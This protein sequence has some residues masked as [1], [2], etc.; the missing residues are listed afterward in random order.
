MGMVG[1]PAA[2]SQTLPNGFTVQTLATGISRPTCMAFAP[3]GRLFI[4]EQNGAIKVYKNG[5][6]LGTSF[7]Q[8]SVNNSGERGLLGLEFDP[9]YATNGYVYV[10]YTQPVSPIRNQVSRLTSNPA[11]PDVMLA[12]SESLVLEFDPLNATNHNG[13]SIKFGPDG[14]LYVAIGENAVTANAQNYDNYLGKLLRINADGSAPADNPF[15]TATPDGTPPT[16]ASQRLW[17]LGLRNPYSFAIDPSAGTIFVNDV[18][19]NQYE[20]INDATLGGNNF[21]WPTQEGPPLSPFAGPAYY[22]KNRYNGG[23]TDSSGCSV[24]GG[25]FLSPLSSN[26]PAQYLG[27]YFF[28]DYCSGW[29]RYIDPAHIP[30]NG[31]TLF[32]NGFGTGL[33]SMVTGSDGNLYYLNRTTSSLNRIVYTP[34]PLESIAS[35]NWNEAATWSCACVP[36]LTD[37]VIV[38]T[39]HSVVI[40]GFTA[41]AKNVALDGGEVRI[42]NNG[43]LRLNH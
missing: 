2:F 39:G 27:K 7:A 23:N 14:K 17:A 8:L 4:G 3:D 1:L 30:A 38:H 41:S 29:F 31:S 34:P 33:V 22:Y 9:D 12:G 18:G 32:A 6:L 19:G 43:S 15:Y 24:L 11:N 40:D 10:Y 13:G 35:G 42:E 16:A 26:Y 28:M 36:A 21:G 5:A 37:E 25:T 20:E